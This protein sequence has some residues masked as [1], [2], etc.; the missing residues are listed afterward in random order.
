MPVV[1]YHGLQDQLAAY[2]WGTDA[3]RRWVELNGCAG[4]PARTGFGASY[5][6][7]YEACNDDVQV[8]F[9]TLDPMGHC[10]PGGSEALCVQGLGPFNDDINANEHMWQFFERYML[11]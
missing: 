1:A 9:C 11:P 6:E 7:S 3:I 10:W 5:C 4:S 2:E 8:T